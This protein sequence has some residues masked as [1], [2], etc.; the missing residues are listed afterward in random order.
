MP[1]LLDLRVL[2]GLLGLLNLVGLLGWSEPVAGGS[3]H[4]DV[5]ASVRLSVRGPA[6]AGDGTKQ[7][8]C[9]REHLC[10]ADGT[11]KSEGS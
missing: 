6:Q 1:L 2:L 8:T 11:C 3:V 5:V 4:I 9:D 7:G 10:H